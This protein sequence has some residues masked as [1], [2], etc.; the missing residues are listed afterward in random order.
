MNS[1]QAQKFRNRFLI[2]LG[3]GLLLVCA[4]TENPFTDAEE[5]Q[6]TRLKGYVVLEDMATPDQ[7]YVWVD[8]FDR[9]DFTKEQGTFSIPIPHA[10]VQGEGQ[11]LNGEALVYFYLANYK[12][13]KIPVYFTDGELTRGQV[14]VD[15]KGVFKEAVILPKLLDIKTTISD[16]TTVVIGDNIYSSITIQVDLQAHDYALRVSCFR[17]I[18]EM[19]NMPAYR[20]GIVF[21]PIELEPEY[22]RFLHTSRTQLAYDSLYVNDHL[23]WT[24]DYDMQNFEDFMPGDYRVYPYLIIQQPELIPED[25]YRI[26]W[27][28]SDLGRHFDVFSWDYHLLPM[29]RNDA[30]ITIQ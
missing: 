20:R 10:E 13:I 26:Q 12:L 3:I 7:V 1:M 15:D 9:S 18:H 14:N 17:Q 23:T 30:L 5:F 8:A 21:E 27:I 22:T 16:T 19:V 6:E 29:R 4:C 11:G 28:T 25:F 24:V 2:I